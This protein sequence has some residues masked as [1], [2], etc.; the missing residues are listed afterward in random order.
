MSDH[1]S[2]RVQIKQDFTADAPQVNASALNSKTKSDM[3]RNGLSTT[4]NVNFL[5]KSK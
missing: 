3:S 2:K 5:S 1:S 4:Y